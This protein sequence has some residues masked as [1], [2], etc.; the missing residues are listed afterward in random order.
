LKQ[1]AEDLIERGNECQVLA[2]DGRWYPAR[3]LPF[4][5]LALR[6]REAWDVLRGRADA[7]YWR[8]NDA[9]R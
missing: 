1:Y 6:L 4:Q 8:Q 9:K 3:P 7:Y 2:A 5:S